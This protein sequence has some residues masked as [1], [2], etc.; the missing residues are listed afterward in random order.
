MKTD[1][2]DFSWI[3]ML[4][5]VVLVF[6]LVRG[7]KRG[8]SEELLD[9]IKW[10]LIVFGAA[11]LYEPAGQ[12]LAQ[13][14]VFSL[15]SCYVAIY[16]SIAL[17]VVIFFS[18]VRHGVGQKLVGSDVFG[19]AEYYLGMIAGMI[20]YA[21]ITLVI[22]AILN[23]RYF[24]AEELQTENKFQQD[25]FGS[26]Y[27]PTISMLQREVFGHSWTGRAARDYLGILLIRPTAPEDKSLGSGGSV[28][29]AREKA[30]N[31]MLENKR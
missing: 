26:T 4:I 19:D 29:R 14:S 23:A 17:V 12:F 6:G 9:L 24:S 5:V 18:F 8:M 11:F 28:V 25:N 31:E 10:V 21:C 2:F 13:N 22:L 7:R 15:L 27:F 16:S 3:D 30:V 1:S 20:R